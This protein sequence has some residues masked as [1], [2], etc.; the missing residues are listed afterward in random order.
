MKRCGRKKTKLLEKAF[1]TPPPLLLS[2]FVV[3]EYLPVKNL[4][5]I[6]LAQQ[7]FQCISICLEY[8]LEATVEISCASGCVSA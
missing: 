6:I 4:E 8:I 2:H 3:K 7:R 1:P 5:I